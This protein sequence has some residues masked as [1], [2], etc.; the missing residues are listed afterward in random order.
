VED[1]LFKVTASGSNKILP[2]AKGLLIAHPETSWELVYPF[3]EDDF[4]DAENEVLASK[5]GVFNINTANDQGQPCQIQA[6]LI[7]TPDREGKI[8][9]QKTFYQADS[10]VAC[11]WAK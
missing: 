5:G 8:Q 4:A 1:T 3:A 7:L 10:L 11:G 2:Y 6:V 9:G